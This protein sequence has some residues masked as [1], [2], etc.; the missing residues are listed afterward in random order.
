MA[1]FPGK[2]FK[3]S[4]GCRPNLA[5]FSVRVFKVCFQFGVPVGLENPHTSRLWLIPQL[6][7]LSCNPSVHVC[8]T[9]YCQDGTPWRKRTRI[10]Y[11]NEDFSLVGRLCC[12]KHGIC[13]RSQQPHVQL[14][15]QQGGQFLTL[16][17]QPYPTKLC[18]RVAGRFH[19]AIFDFFS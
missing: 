11:S 4:C 15:G 6:V 1:P 5:R 9:D 18:N 17:A 8:V 12:G 13:S 2:E 19:N 14:V 3:T 16:Q 7:K 10:L